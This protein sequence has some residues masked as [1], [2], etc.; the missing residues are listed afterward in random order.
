M[1]HWLSYF[2]TRLRWW[3]VDT[4][5]VVR[6]PILS[7]HNRQADKEVLRRSEV[8]RG[9]RTAVLVGG[10]R[11]VNTHHPRQCVGQ[12][13]CIHH[14]S[15]HHMVTWTQHWRSDRGIMERLCPDRG[16]GHPDP[17]DINADQ[18]HGCD[19]CCITPGD[20]PV[21]RFDMVFELPS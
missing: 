13:C 7:W 6:H 3:Y 2:V 17:D 1:R 8:E 15:D 16:I 10:Q 11:L 14:P 18:V 5:L 20:V 19:G 9:E 12:S 21:D 4:Y